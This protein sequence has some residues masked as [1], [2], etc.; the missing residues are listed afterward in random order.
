[1]LLSLL[2]AIPLAQA[3]PVADPAAAELHRVA[4]LGDSITWGARLDD[5]ARHS[6]PALLGALLGDAYAVRN[7]GVGGAT[8]LG[9]ADKPYVAQSAFHDLLAW[10]PHTV[11]VVLGTNDTCATEARRNWQ[12]HEDLEGDARA[13]A[14]SLFDAGAERVLFC[15]PPRMFPDRAG[16]PDQRVADLTERATR[17]P[18]IDAALRAAFD[19][20]GGGGEVV[21]LDG[22]LRADW[23]SDGVH[24]TPHGCDALSL[25]IA[26]AL[27]A[28]RFARAAAL[29]ARPSAEWRGQAAGWGGGN[30]HDAVAHLRTQAE[31]HR[32]ARIVFL[33]DSITQSLTGHRERWAGPPYAAED[34]RRARAIDRS[35]GDGGALDLGLSGDRTAH[36]LWR[37]R[38]G[39][40]PLL[41]P[42]VIVLQIGINNLVAGGESAADT[43]AGIAAVVDALRAAQPQ[44]RVIVCG[45]FPGGRAA[46]HPLR[47]KV[48]AVHAR[49]AALE[50]LERVDYLDLRG[51][52]ID[53]NGDANGL[54]AEDGIHI[55]EAGRLWWMARI[56]AHLDLAAD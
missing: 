26:A 50:E 38:H 25:R 49:I 29:V 54:L 22:V 51:A 2:L 23:T 52:F 39:A 48:D 47:A 10:R 19:A 46:D 43:A 37:I 18:V 21:A 6:Y 36:L 5:R 33:G 56:R 8:L 32:D 4:C 20:P 45:P 30:W 11:V 35:F 44:A 53:D 40:L 27:D 24:P 7:F 42:A 9:A 14:A 3:A 55:T 15:T 1:V 28:D 12:H 41:S 34:R 31:T 16:L 13:L 17:L